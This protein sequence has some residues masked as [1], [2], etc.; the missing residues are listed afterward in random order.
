VKVFVRAAQF[1]QEREKMHLSSFARLVGATQQ[2]DPGIELPAGKKDIMTRL[3][4]RL[5]KGPVII[6]RVDQEA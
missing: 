5:I 4:C 6:S 3:F 2:F 1:H